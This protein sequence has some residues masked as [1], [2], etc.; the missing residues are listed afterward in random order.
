MARQKKNDELDITSKVPSGKYKKELVGDNLINDKKE[1]FSL[2]REG[3]RFT[4]DVLSKVGITRKI[5][6]LPHSPNRLIDHVVDNKVYEKD[7][8]TLKNILKSI[9][10]IETSMI[11]ESTEENCEEENN[12]DNDE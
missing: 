10:T 11:T 6:V 12:D 8:M 7:T 4:E 9:H 3:Y 1:V 2:I 5:S